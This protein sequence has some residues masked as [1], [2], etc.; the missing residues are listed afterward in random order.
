MNR[1]LRI[2]CH[3]L[4]VPLAGWY[5]CSRA[6][7]AAP[8]FNP[9]ASA[10]AA[11]GEFDANQDGALDAKELAKCPGLQAARERVD[12]DGSGSLSE[13][14]IAARIGTYGGNAVPL[15]PLRCQVQLDG[16]PLAGANVTLVPEKLLGDAIQA[17]SGVTDA[18]G[19]ALLSIAQFRDQ[20]YSGVFFGLYRVQISLAASGGGERVPPKY[21]VDTTLGLEVAPDIRELEHGVMWNLSS[22]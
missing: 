21:N 22:R 19:N 12:A 1:R 4:L 8:E 13:A 9:G 18:D 2:L 17:A 6:P 16:Q 5:G 20:G 15:T 3:S 10:R 14:E 11:I 7:V